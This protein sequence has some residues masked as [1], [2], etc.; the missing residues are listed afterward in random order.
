MKKFYLTCAFVL[1]AV[2]Y[3]A[4]D[5]AKPVETGKPDKV[6]QPSAVSAVAAT[7]N[8]TSNDCAKLDAFYWE[9]G[10]K[11]G[12]K[13]SGTKGSGYSATSA[14]AIA[15][16]SKWLY[17]AYVTQ[18]KV[19]DA[20]D[21]KYLTHNGGYT[22]GGNLCTPFETVGDC[23]AKLTFDPA[24]VDFF[25]YG[26]GNYQFHATTMG[27]SGLRRAA[28][29][30]VVTT[31]LGLSFDY[32]AAQPPG[33]AVIT[34]AEYGRF[35]RK[36]MNN[37]LTLGG[38]LGTNAVCTQ[39]STCPTSLYTAIPPGYSFLYSIG[40][41]VEDDGSFS[42]AGAFGFY[43]WISADKAAYGIVARKDTFGQGSAWDSRQCGAA[44][45]RAYLSGVAQ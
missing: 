15:S 22:D 19:L 12:A 40:H 39:R 23:A 3:S 5:A 8:S 33:G 21:I 41:W 4:A 44:I 7:A 29:A 37:E 18:T 13:V 17:A 25:W 10:D 27:L 36:M 43:P 31:K 11:S 34:P 42:S 32:S 30:N 2:V 6:V 24:A 16:S 26:G 1:L 9:V 28:L 35:L 14:L 20:T 45:R 38:L